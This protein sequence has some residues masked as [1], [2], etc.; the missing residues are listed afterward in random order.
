MASKIKEYEIEAEH[1]ELNVT[2]SEW[3]GRTNWT[4][5][6]TMNRSDDPN[7]SH[8]PAWFS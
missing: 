2:Q 5:D 1:F 6:P 7:C 3:L 8:H 4:K